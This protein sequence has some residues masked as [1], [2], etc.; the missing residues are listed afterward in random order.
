MGLGFWLLTR[1]QRR[2]LGLYCIRD[3]NTH[4]HT[5]THTHACTHT[6]TG[7]HARTHVH[8]HT[9]GGLRCWTQVCWCN[10]RERAADQQRGGALPVIEG[11]TGT[12]YSW[13]FQPQL[14]HRVLC[15]HQEGGHVSERVWCFHA[16]LLH[17]WYGGVC[18][19]VCVFC[20]L[21][22]LPS[23]VGLEGHPPPPSLIKS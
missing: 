20:A 19:C 11:N 10:Q 12:Y 9:H 4:T 3:S 7:T 14:I 8:T 16:V 13:V 17:V 18:V 2:P 5:H 21:V 15:Y 22:R 6:H 23:A 1:S